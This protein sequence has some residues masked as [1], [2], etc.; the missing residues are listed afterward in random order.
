MPVHLLVLI[1]VNMFTF[2][3]ETAVHI[4]SISWF[5]LRYFYMLEV[6]WSL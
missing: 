4:S 2:Y 1:N 5:Y 3:P 6:I